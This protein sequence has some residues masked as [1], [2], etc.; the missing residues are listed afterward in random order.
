MGTK[1]KNVLASNRID[2]K[3]GGNAAEIASTCKNQTIPSI[4]KRLNL[5]AHNPQP[6]QPLN[7]VTPNLNV[8]SFVNNGSLTSKIN[9][10]T[11]VTAINHHSSITK[12]NKNPRDELTKD[13]KDSYMP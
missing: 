13:L 8:Q 2:V 10:I 9:E 1:G 4:M 5:N 11:P 7:N 6:Q 3:M 12:R